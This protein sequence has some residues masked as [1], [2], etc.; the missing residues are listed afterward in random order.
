MSLTS[1][2]GVNIIG[3]GLAGSLLAIL[4]AKRGLRVTV[5]ERRADPRVS[6]VDGGRSIN[7][8][9]AARG[10]R[11]L[12]LAGM[13]ERVMPLAIPMRGRMV[14]EH[15]GSAELQMYGVRPEEVIYSVSRADLNRALI[16]AAANLPGVEFNFGR[17]CLGLA[18][19]KSVLEFR[20]EASGRIY[21]AA[22]TPSIATDGAGSAVRDSLL[23]REVATVR[24][25]PLEHDYKE[26]TI[27]AAGGKHV[28]DPNAL[29]IWPRGGFML[30][31]LPNRDGTFTATLFLA[32]SGVNGFEQL[33][34]PGDVEAF[35]GR[36]FPSARGLMPD[37]THE[38]FENPQGSLGTVYT[39]GWHLNG[40]LLLLGDA[41][42]A[43]VPF[44]GQGM[45]CAFEDCA[46]LLRLMDEHHSWPGLFEAFEH[47]RRPNTDA[48]AQMALENYREMREAVLDP[49]YRRKKREAEELEKK[50]PNFIPRYSM[51]MFHPEIAYREALSRSST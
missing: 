45:N 27:P 44:H 24:E 19:E 17:L 29:H 26:L 20:D 32:R 12:Q 3:A 18:H 39:R 47:E 35:F 5:Y 33:R 11:G 9:L 22:A 42:H 10:I 31:A 40:D 25:E 2:P 46:E 1:V 51:V 38:F 28:M 34:S 37:L 49:E 7:L 43:I 8:A 50:D 30:I 15:D 6:T 16:E 36:E 13:L 4:L 21:H 48:I 23:A 41:A 14:H